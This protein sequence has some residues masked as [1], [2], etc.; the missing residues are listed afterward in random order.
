MNAPDQVNT[1]TSECVQ[2]LKPDI[3]CLMGFGLR[4]ASSKY[5]FSPVEMEDVAARETVDGRRFHGDDLEPVHG[6]LLIQ[7]LEVIVVTPGRVDE[8]ALTSGSE[9]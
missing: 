7:Q 6:K 3:N 9:R 8:K 2:P 5:P 1:L 4:L